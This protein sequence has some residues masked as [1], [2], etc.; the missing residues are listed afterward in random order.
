MEQE[1]KDR[2]AALRVEMS[3]EVELVQQ[4]AIQQREELEQEIR[5]IR[6]DETFIR[7]HLTLTIKVI[8]KHCHSLLHFTGLVKK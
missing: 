8:T 7:E 4:Q 5:R 6:D 1:H 3:K 2:M